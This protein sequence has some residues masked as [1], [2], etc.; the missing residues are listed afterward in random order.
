VQDKSQ[1]KRADR[2]GGYFVAYEV[3]AIFSSQT[4][5][6]VTSV[7]LRF[8]SRT[9]QKMENP[10]SSGTRRDRFHGEGT[11]FAGLDRR[12]WPVTPVKCARNGSVCLP[13]LACPMPRQCLE[14]SGRQKCNEA[15]VT[16]IMPEIERVTER[17]MKT[18]STKFSS[19]SRMPRR[20]NSTPLNSLM[21]ATQSFCLRNSR[22]RP[23]AS[24]ERI[25]PP[26]KVRASQQNRASSRAS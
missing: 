4:V 9:R 24:T 25:G 22:S 3:R 17:R 1:D 5:M 14:K 18:S 7:T 15:E 11:A 13:P 10:P 23:S 2:A 12:G 26:R 20:V 16:T 6:P 8:R 21:V 19:S